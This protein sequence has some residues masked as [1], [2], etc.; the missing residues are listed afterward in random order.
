MLVLTFRIGTNRLALDTR[1]VREVVPRV[2]LR[3]LS[4]G[5]A[6]LAGVFIYRGQVVPVVDLHRLFGAGECPQHLSSRI[7][8]VPAGPNGEGLL[9]LLGAQVADLREIEAPA[10]TARHLSHPGHPDL[11][12]L[13]V[14]GKDVLHLVQLDRLLPDGMRQQLTA[15]PQELPA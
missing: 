5:P 12:A 8:L 6:W 4:S 7:I 10:S 13:L 1:Q 3:P 9:G 11:G 2:E 15:L 14:D